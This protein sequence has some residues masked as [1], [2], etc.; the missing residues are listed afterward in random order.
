[1]TQNDLTGAPEDAVLIELIRQC[2][3]QQ[4]QLFR[5]V[6]PRAIHEGAERQGLPQ[7]GLGAGLAEK[8]PAKCS[9][10]F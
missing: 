2:K 8:L 3:C 4:T 9:Q 6:S 7:Y 5:F 10:Y 1:M